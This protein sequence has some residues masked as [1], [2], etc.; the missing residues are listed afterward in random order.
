[1]RSSGS[2]RVAS[3]RVGMTEQ[4]FRQ[5][6]SVLPIARPAQ[7]IK[8]NSPTLNGKRTYD[9]AGFGTKGANPVGTVTPTKALTTTAT[10][11]R[12]SV[13]RVKPDVTVREDTELSIAEMRAKAEEEHAA[14]LKTWIASYKK[15]FPSLRFFFDACSEDDVRRCTR[16]IMA[17]GGVSPICCSRLP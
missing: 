3:L 6:L 11:G 7:N 4:I 8:N 12:R 5:P 14:K 2:H 15:Q 16:K 13:K 10:N 1:M 9:S 17:L